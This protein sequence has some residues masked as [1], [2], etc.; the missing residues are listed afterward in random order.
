MRWGAFTISKS[1]SFEPRVG[2]KRLTDQ[3]QLHEN[4]APEADNIQQFALGTHEIGAKTGEEAP[5][6][7]TY[8]GAEVDA[9]LG[10]FLSRPIAI[11][12][13]TWT[14]NTALERQYF[15]WELYLTNQ[16]VKEKLRGFRAIR[17]NLHIRITVA[18]S[19]FFSGAL[20]ASYQPL[21]LKDPQRDLTVSSTYANIKRSQRMSFLID[22]ATSRG[23]EMVCPFL[24]PSNGV[25]VQDTGALQALG[26]L[27]IS[28]LSILKKVS[29]SGSMLYLVIYAWM[30]DVK[31]IGQTSVDPFPP[32]T[33]TETQMAGELDSKGPVSKVA[34]S[35]QG[36]A[37]AV[38]NVPILGEY[39]KA[40]E[41]VAKGIGAAAS[42]LGY[43]RPSDITNPTKILTFP[44]T[45]LATTN[46][47]VQEYVIATD[48]RNEMT[49]DPNVV[50]APAED[51]LTFEHFCNR[52]SY[53]TSFFIDLS[54]QNNSTLFDSVVSPMLFQYLNNILYS[55][56]MSFVAQN[57]IWW[58]G[59][60]VFKFVFHTSAFHKGKIRV[61]YDA[62]ADSI[63]PTTGVVNVGEHY[64][65]DLSKEREFSVR[66]GW[67]NEK[68][69]LPISSSFLNPRFNEN[70]VVG[71]PDYIAAEGNG[72]LTLFLENGMTS[73][74]ATDPSDASITC[75][76]FVH[77]ENVAFAGPDSA[78]AGEFSLTPNVP[79]PPVL[80]TETQMGMVETTEV[81]DAQGAVHPTHDFANPVHPDPNLDLVHMG[82]RVTSWRQLLK[83]FCFYAAYVN[84]DDPTLY[85]MAP[86]AR[87][88][89]N[90]MPIGRGYETTGVGAIALPHRHLVYISLLSAC[91]HT[92]RGGVRWHFS[93]SNEA[94][95]RVTVRYST[96][97]AQPSGCS[98]GL[99]DMDGTDYDQMALYA[100]ICDNAMSGI[101]VLR[102]DGTFMVPGSNLY[103][104]RHREDRIN[105]N[106]WELAYRTT[107]GEDSYI[108]LYVAGAEDL[109]FQA[110]DA[111]PT[112]FNVGR[113]EAS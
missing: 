23:G 65:V 17:G 104:F 105:E 7:Q 54:T 43:S 33:L 110:F 74:Y 89:H 27:T 102:K 81:G 31:Y 12:K 92:N 76:V 73:P 84:K 29:D 38:S 82:E 20:L 101:A 13:P 46:E 39:A 88:A 37:A 10:E 98:R 60:I 99:T 67:A 94:P 14:V 36:A 15:P 103:R 93:S 26:E 57:F 49:I 45:P 112:L 42:A 28:N 25:L 50:G 109:T 107:P 18:G 70:A 111:C 55:T 108:L 56:P 44:T 68:N 9:G 62:I 8:Y 19:P 113:H 48:V 61:S 4:L 75:S 6:D 35:V 52:E 83:R 64:I 53:L 86:L 80:L 85:T 96:R 59:N 63:A 2:C 41:M 40:T 72:K 51:E 100:R 34:S 3:Q 71:V 21:A 11:R 47:R 97:A 22:A 106:E 5:I 79:S 24:W 16:R 95:I 78:Y 66:V 69:W 1:L 90:S 91:F 30:T 77:A 32:V 58:R 87:L